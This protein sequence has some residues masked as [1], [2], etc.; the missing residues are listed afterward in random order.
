MQLA[1]KVLLSSCKVPFRTVASSAISRA[2]ADAAS[3][4]VKSATE[5]ILTAISLIKQS[6]VAQDDRCRVLV[7]SLQ[8]RS[9]IT[10]SYFLICFLASLFVGED[11][12]LICLQAV[13]LF[14]LNK[15]CIKS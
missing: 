7:V 9:L 4:D 14:V 13:G 11:I 5:T 1:Y 2:V 8:V 6:R 15:L 12:A 3:G 10:S